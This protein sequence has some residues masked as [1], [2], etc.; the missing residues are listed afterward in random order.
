MHVTELTILTTDYATDS[1]RLLVYVWELVCVRV[2]VYV[3]VVDVGRARILSLVSLRLRQLNHRLLWQWEKKKS[4]AFKFTLWA[5]IKG[6]GCWIM[7]KSMV[8]VCVCAVSCRCC[9]QY[10]L[11]C[12][13]TEIPVRD[14]LFIKA[15]GL[16][17][18][19][20]VMDVPKENAKMLKSAALPCWCPDWETLPS[21][22]MIMQRLECKPG[23]V[24]RFCNAKQWI[25]PQGH[26]SL[27]LMLMWCSED[28]SVWWFCT[29]CTME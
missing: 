19:I 2:W 23:C 26:S 12:S 29:A 24:A 1:V 8:C 21:F 11:V 14:K 22:S 17:F 15:T 13:R 7:A 4:M 3:C 10:I 20:R 9:S 27:W 28:L 5:N 16:L 6:K 18:T 25:Y